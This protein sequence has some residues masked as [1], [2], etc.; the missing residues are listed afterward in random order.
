MT[1]TNQTLPIFDINNFNLSF[2]KLDNYFQ[3]HKIS[4]EKNKF[5]TLINLI[6]PFTFPHLIENALL[7]SDSEE[8]PYTTL[9][10][11]LLNETQPTTNEQY[12]KLL[13][14]TQARTLSPKNFLLDLQMKAPSSEKNGS[15]LKHLFLANQ[16]PAIRMVLATMP[17]KTLNEMADTAER[18]WQAS[19]DA[20]NSSVN[21]VTK[22]SEIQELK[23]Q[24]SSLA[25]TIDDMKMASITQVDFKKQTP[26]F[27]SRKMP[28]PGSGWNNNKRYSQTYEIC[29][30][31]KK[32][33][34][35]ARKCEPYC[36]YFKDKREPQ[37]KN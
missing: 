33:G 1:N 24:I 4:D 27:S 16:E 10:K 14:T 22:N 15:L 23:E 7:H 30:F 29:Y 34:K 3:T 17:D 28:T 18:M 36:R 21:T 20:S 13:H 8:T 31:H 12:L 25:K 19:N 26:M 9:K 2:L 5:S 37:S 35:E 6:P 11:K 32:F